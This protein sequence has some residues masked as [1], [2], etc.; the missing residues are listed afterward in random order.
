[1]R[2]VILYC[3]ASLDGYIARKDGSVDWLDSIPNPEHSDY[4]YAQFYDSIDVTLMGNG[5]YKAVLGFGVDFP[6]QEKTNYVFSRTST[7]TDAPFIQYINDDVISFVNELKTKP[8]KNIWLV[9]GGQLNTTLLN[10]GLI[11]ELIITLFPIIL[12]DGIPTFADGALESHFKVVENK[13][14]D[15]GLVQLTLNKK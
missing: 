2:K 15:N 8:G 9:G 7:G 13:T 4:G 1:M 3:A 12:G 5:T 10:A 14:F 11:D 6:Y